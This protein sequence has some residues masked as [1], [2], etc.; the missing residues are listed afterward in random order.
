MNMTGEK[1]KWAV[2]I[3]LLLVAGLFLYFLFIY[4][5]YT[6]CSEPEG[7]LRTMD[8]PELCEKAGGNYIEELTTCQLPTSDAGKACKNKSQC[9]G[10]CEANLSPDEIIK[11]A[12]GERVEKTGTCGRWKNFFSGCFY[13]VE[14]GIAERLCAD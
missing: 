7:R 3:L 1:W 6:C 4:F 9:D 11:I 10:F 8:I 13:V 2:A 14:G 12:N 5:F